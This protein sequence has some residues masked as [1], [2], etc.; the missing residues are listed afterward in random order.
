MRPI[1]QNGRNNGTAIMYEVD[2]YENLKEAVKFIIKF[3]I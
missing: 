2:S 3:I 1:D